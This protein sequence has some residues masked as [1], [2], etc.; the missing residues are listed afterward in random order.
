MKLK[1]TLFLSL[2]MLTTFSIMVVPVNS[3]GTYLEKGS[4]GASFEPKTL[5]GTRIVLED[6][7]ILPANQAYHIWQGWYQ[8]G[9]K[10]LSTIDKEYFKLLTMKLTIDGE[11]VKLHTWKHHYKEVEYN[12]KIL[13]DVMFKIFYVEFK[14]GYFQVGDHSFLLKA[15]NIP[16]IFATINFT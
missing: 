14:E 5:D 4:G 9:W 1:N 10:D 11:P 15:T 16:D 6:G 2:F 13:V 7:L 12:G 3:V 8:E